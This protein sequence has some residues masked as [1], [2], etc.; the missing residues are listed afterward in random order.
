MEVSRIQINI[1][2]L[3]TNDVTS[4]AAEALR[5]DE[6]DSKVERLARIIH[7]KTEG[8]P[9]FVSMFLISLYDDKILQY[10]FGTMRWIWDDVAV[11][12][13]TVTDNVASVLVNKMSRLK[14]EVRMVL[15]VASC[16]GAH[17]RLPVLVKIMKNLS[18]RELRSSLRSS[19]SSEPDITKDIVFEDASSS[20]ISSSIDEAEVEGLV[21]T[22]NNENCYFVH[23]QIQLAAFELISPENRDEFRGK[24]GSIMHRTLSSGEVESNIFEIVGMLNCALSFISDKDRD[25]LA[26][27]N[28]KAG[29]KASENG[30]FD[31]AKVYYEAGRKALGSKAWERNFTTML[32]LC[33][34][35]ANACYL[36]GDFE[37]MNELIDEVLSQD[38]DV[39]GKYRVTEVKVKSLYAQEKVN[40]SIDVALDFRCQLGLPTLQRKRFSMR[41]VLGEYIQVMRLLKKM[42]VEEIVHCPDLEDE[43]YEMGQRMNEL[44]LP[45]IYQVERTMVP[46]IV[47]QMLTTTLKHGLNPTSCVALATHGAILCGYFD[48]PHQGRELAKAAELI[49]KLPGM[50]RIT[51]NAIFI[52]QTYCYHWTSPLQDTISPLLNGCEEGLATGDIES[53]CQSLLHRCLNLYFTGRSLDSIQEEVGASIDVLTRLK[54]G[55]QRALVEILQITVK[56]LRGIDTEGNDEKMNSIEEAAIATGDSHQAAYVSS[57]K[58]EVLVVLQKWEEALEFVQKA[59]EIRDST[60]S[61]FLSVRFTFLEALTYLKAAQIVTGFNRIKMKRRGKK[62]MKLLR[63]WA[64]NGNVNV[65]H[66]LHILEAEVFFLEGK[67]KKAGES[68][69]VAISSSRR[70]GFLHDRALA[71]ELSS[72]FYAARGDEFWSNYHIECAKTCYKEWGCSKKVD[73]LNIAK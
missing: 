60:K 43:R 33:S 24:I 9:F 47:F 23:D 56:K 46:L 8:N 31:T 4:L 40:E 21:E 42:S 65:V 44:L 48:K 52:S 73:Q 6:D 13:R 71:H 25:Q 26:E 66:Y 67:M 54:Q 1:G 22:D 11:E 38:I 55:E 32:D 5:M 35:G 27:L 30:A 50:R 61:A 51:S 49:L 64:K 17:F 37:S 3:I 14:E 72:S 16:L 68:F 15:M 62:A 58:L 53:A 7:R 69:K 29:A 57:F 45:S 39:I 59:N 36:T 20:S 10:S 34:D 41:T 28:L 70:N 19:S 18:D 63:G 2:N 12:S